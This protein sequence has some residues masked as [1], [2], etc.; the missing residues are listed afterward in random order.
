MSRGDSPENLFFL[1]R[2]SHVRSQSTDAQRLAR[3]WDAA[4]PRV[5]PP[6]AGWQAGNADDRRM[7]GR[8]PN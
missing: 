4:R 3:E 8:N 7:T 2:P 6:D 5:V 1:R